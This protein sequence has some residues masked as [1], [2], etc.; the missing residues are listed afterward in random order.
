MNQFK[1]TKDLVS[2]F[3]LLKSKPLDTPINTSEKITK[4]ID[5]VNVDSTEY[6]SIIGSLLYLIISKPN[7]VFSVGVYARY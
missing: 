5:G 4:D 3:G 1:Y 2:K 6:R 7:I